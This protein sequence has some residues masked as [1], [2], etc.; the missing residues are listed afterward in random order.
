MAAYI[1]ALDSGTHADATAAQSAITGAGATITETYSFNLTYKIDCTAEQLA[2]IAGVLHSSLDSAT[3]NL[4]S[5]YST[6]H[7]KHLCNNVDNSLAT[8]YNP[9]YTGTGSE[10]YLM[11]TGINANHNELASATINNLYSLYEVDSNPDYADSTGHGTAMCSIINGDNIGVSSDAKVHNVKVMNASTTSLTVGNMISALNQVLVHH[12]A[13]TPSKVKAVCIPWITAKNNLIDAKLQELES[14]NLMVVCSAGNNAADVDNYS[15]AGLDQVMTVGAYNTSYE[16]GAFGANATWTGGSAGSNLGEEV[17]IYALGSNVSIAD[18]SNVSNYESAYGTSVSTAIIAGL[19]AQYIQDNPTA[20]STQIKSFMV[21]KGL[22]KGRGAN[23]TFNA[24]LITSTGANAD[25][26]TKS[27]GVSLQSGQVTLSE[28]PS[29]L[30]LTVANGQS[31]SANVG[32]NVNASNVE[33]LAFSPVPPFATF[34][35]ST[36]VISAD[37]SANMSGVT[38]PGKYHFAVR[39]VIG[40]VT[41]VEEYTIGVYTSSETELDASPEYYWDG[42]SYDQVVNFTSTKE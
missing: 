9:Q 7:L 35:T 3:E 31:G 42:S 29:G 8:A 12:N 30:V 16:V 10:I 15:P 11:D 14:H 36:G 34:N 39:G 27:I 4:S 28:V 6:D 37:T 32:L 41:K 22:D 5:Q 2:A 20:T 24:G 26:L 21:A 19:S 18:H 17:D 33:V 23:L 1:V 13:N 40:G 38:V 25:I